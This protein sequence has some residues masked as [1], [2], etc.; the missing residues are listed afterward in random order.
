MEF[1][2][3]PCSTEIQAGT[4]FQLPLLI[5][6]KKTLLSYEFQSKDYDV[7]FQIVKVEKDGEE[8]V[9]VPI[10]PML[11]YGPNTKHTGS[12]ILNESGNYLL[13]WDNTHSWLRGK[14][15]NYKIDLSRVKR[16]AEEDIAY[17]R[18]VTSTV[19]RLA[20]QLKDTKHLL[21][22]REQEKSDLKDRYQSVVKEMQNVQVGSSL[23]SNDA[24]GGVCKRRCDGRSGGDDPRLRAEGGGE[25]EGD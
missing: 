17:N 20:S 3:G 1:H 10:T 13:I 8:S 14:E 12:K 16:T 21:E 4:T 24:D 7:L 2:V 15:I 11:S 6:K 5:E 23:S 18:S 22:S 9:T 25:G 19:S